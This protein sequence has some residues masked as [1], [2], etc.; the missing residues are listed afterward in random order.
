MLTLAEAAA[1]DLP[2]TTRTP[3]WANP[4]VSQHNI[5]ATVCKSGWTKTIRPKTS[6]TNKLKI[7]QI[8]EYHYKDKNPK[9]YEEDHLISLQLGG[10]PTDPRNLWP[11]P[12]AGS[13]GARIKDVL[14]TKLKKLVCAGDLT[15]ADAQQII[16]NDWVSAYQ[17]YVNSDGCD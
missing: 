4:G 7:K 11:Q 9:S 2:N 12:Y 15:L 17:Q 13:C 14:E 5:A 10:H 16:A 8:A 3:G 1:G 6:Y